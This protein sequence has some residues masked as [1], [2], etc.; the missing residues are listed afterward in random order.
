M[1]FL[2]TSSRREIILVIAL[3]TAALIFAD[4]DNIGAFPSVRYTLPSLTE[5]RTKSEDET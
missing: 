5:N 3:G 1:G 2:M 4:S